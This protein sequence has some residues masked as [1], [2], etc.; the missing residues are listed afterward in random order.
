MNGTHERYF[1]RACATD[2]LT[3]EALQFIGEYIDSLRREECVTDEDY[4]HRL[5]QCSLC[6][7]LSDGNTCM[8]CGCL[9]MVR[10]KKIKMGCPHPAGSRWLH[11]V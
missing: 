10:A 9:V 3:K 1:C 5:E 2:A 7:A 8:H 4:R 6:P 11:I